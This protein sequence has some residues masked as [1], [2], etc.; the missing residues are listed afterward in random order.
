[1][2]Q[3]GARARKPK[4][5]ARAKRPVAPRVSYP[6]PARGSDAETA[7]I[8][9]NSYC[10]RHYAISYTGGTPRRLTLDNKDVWIVP[11]VFTSP[12]YGIVGE[13]GVVAVDAVTHEIA[14][15][16]PREEVRAA[17][18]K[19]AEEKRDEL[20]AAFLRARTAR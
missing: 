19:L 2:P 11:V 5:K 20:H 13:V 10:V 15:A 9:A 7:Q 18:A 4:A 6:P 1:M 16:S 14:G 8:A 3:K 17:G 12:G